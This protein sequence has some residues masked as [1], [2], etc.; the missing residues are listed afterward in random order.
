MKLRSPG[1]P[2]DLEW[3]SE[4]GMPLNLASSCKP[5][6]KSKEIQSN[7]GQNIDRALIRKSSFLPHVV[8]QSNLEYPA[9]TL[10]GAASPE[11]NRER[12]AHSSRGF[13]NSNSIPFEA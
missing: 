6:E 11:P 7:A 4:T 2:A 12:G 5:R 9:R 8:P 13:M 10:D 3:A 1:L